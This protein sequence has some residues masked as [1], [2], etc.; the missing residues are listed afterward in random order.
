MFPDE[1]WWDRGWIAAELSHAFLFL[2]L[3]SPLRSLQ[4]PFD[5]LVG[6][7]LLQSTLMSVICS[8]LWLFGGVVPVNSWCQVCFDFIA[9]QSVFYKGLTQLTY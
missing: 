9:L 1:A 8:F 2:T 3:D 5:G 4:W 7:Q 6:E